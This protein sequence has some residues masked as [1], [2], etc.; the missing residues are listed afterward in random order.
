MLPGG[1]CVVG[2]MSVGAVVHGDCGLPAR[3]CTIARGWLSC[4]GWWLAYSS[5]CWSHLGPSEL[6]RVYWFESFQQLGVVGLH[7]GRETLRRRFHA[8]DVTPRGPHAGCCFPGG[9]ATTCA[10]KKGPVGGWF[11]GL[12]KLSTGLR[13]G[14][15]EMEGHTQSGVK[16]HTSTIGREKVLSLLSGLVVGGGGLVGWLVGRN[17]LFDMVY[18]KST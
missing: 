5:G 9:S 7:K 8:T 17:G 13:C 10:V 18:R 1:I 12:S 6:E 11:V 15:R 3:A 2:G 14:C 16:W 4:W